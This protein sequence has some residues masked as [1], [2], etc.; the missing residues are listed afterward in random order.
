MLEITVTSLKF[1]AA[2]LIKVGPPISIYSIN[3][4]DFS[5]SCFSNG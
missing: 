1:L 4:L 3:F 2:A 5:S